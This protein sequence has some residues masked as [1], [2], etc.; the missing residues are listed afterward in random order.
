[1]KRGCSNQLLVIVTAIG[2]S[3]PAVAEVLF[4]GTMKI[5]EVSAACEG[6]I[7]ANWSGH[8]SYHPSVVT[9]GT[10][11]NNFSALN[12]FFE[13]AA[14]SW[15][16]AGAGFNTT[17]R[18]VTCNGIGW[19]AYDCERPSYIRITSQSPAILTKTTP[20]VALAGQIKNF[21]GRTGQEN[22]IATFRMVG[23]LALR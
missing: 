2:L 3:A 21:W 16:L 4:D 13:T 9:G 14:Q 19:S 15:M 23:I 22:C 8:A 17:F 11:N 10:P 18:Q 20:T 7:A 5:T 12:F 1:M 6:W